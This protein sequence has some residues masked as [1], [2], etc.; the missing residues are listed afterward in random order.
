LAIGARYD[1]KSKVRFLAAIL[2][3]GVFIPTLI[4]SG[5]GKGHTDNHD[6]SLTPSEVLNVPLSQEIL[7][8]PTKTIFQRVVQA[9]LYHSGVWTL[10]D[11]SQTPVTAART[12][13]SLQPSFVTGLVRLPDH[14]EISNPEV[15]SFK[16]VR[17]AVLGTEKQCRFDAVVN[18]GGE[19]SGEV[20]L[21]RLREVSLRLH[22]DAWT[23]FV[24]PDTESITPEVFEM[25]ISWAH[26]SG[27]MVG[28]DGPLSLIPEG[29]DYIVVR[30]WDL[31]VNRK[32]IELLRSKNH[33]PIIVELPTSYGGRL[34]ED[35]VEFIEKMDTAKRSDLLTR[36]AEDQSA[37]GYRFAY[38]IFYPLTPQRQAFDATKDGTLLVVIRSLLAR[39]D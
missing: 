20:L 30:A 13:A 14:G 10:S 31:K 11:S 9:R 8:A 18:A 22:P 33:V 27:Q 39:F 28:Y 17:N 16:A 29:V 36:L 6:A 26:S 24:A 23:F 7:K 21:R 5:A 37:W 32:Q 15:E 3:S 2:V 35:S 1:K 4:A 38:P 34:N 25:G 19:K 12:I